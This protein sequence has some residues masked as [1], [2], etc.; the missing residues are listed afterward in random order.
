MFKRL[1]LNDRFILAIILLNSGIIYAQV[2]G[3]NNLYVNIIDIACTLIFAIEMVCKHLEYGI[4]G[5]WKDGWNKLDG[6]LVIFSLPSLV[7]VF[8]PMG[9]HNTSF[10]LILRLLRV[11][12]FF[13]ILHFF[14][15]FS[16]I[17]LAFKVALKESYAILIEFLSY[18]RH[19]WSYQLQFVQ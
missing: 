13:R 19:L 9:M 3:Y 6:T 15:N 18:H 14:P 17:V 8:V 7:E 10:L 1:F 4:R 12:R 11:L 16:K 5:Y 2:S